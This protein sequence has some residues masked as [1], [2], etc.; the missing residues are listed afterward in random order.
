MEKYRISDTGVKVFIDYRD[1]IIIDK[2]NR[3]LANKAVL[4]RERYS[5]GKVK[6]LV[7]FGSENSEDAKTW[8]LFRSLE[9]NKQFDLYYKI[10]G[11]RDKAAKV[12]FW[13]MDSN[14]GEFNSLLKEVLDEIEPPNLWRI[15]QTEPDV[16]I[17]G[18]KTVIFN[19]SKLGKNGTQIDAWNRKDLFEKKHERYKKNAEPYFKSKFIDNFAEEGR[20]YYQL[21]RNLIIGQAFANRLGKQFHLAALVNSKNKAKSGLTHNEEFNNFSLLL[22]DASYCH[23]MTWDQL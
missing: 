10:I 8:N 17:I 12:L 3:V 5:K 23:F 6:D 7:R 14:T 2:D 15:Q 21:L 9:L 18:E 16:I 19:E 11:V 13:G 20:R 4:P 22:N 1:N